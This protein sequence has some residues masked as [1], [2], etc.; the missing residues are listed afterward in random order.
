MLPA[1]SPTRCAISTRRR[2]KRELLPAMNDTGLIRYHVACRA[3]A[4]AKCVD[5]PELTTSGVRGK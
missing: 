2:V 4:A 5:E 1:F 3:L